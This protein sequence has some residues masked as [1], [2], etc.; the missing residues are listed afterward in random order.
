MK[1]AIDIMGFE[2][3]P[4]E[5]INACKKFLKKHQDV[6]FILVGDQKYIDSNLLNDLHFSA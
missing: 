4:I 5:A 1:L 6:D 3:D 2:N